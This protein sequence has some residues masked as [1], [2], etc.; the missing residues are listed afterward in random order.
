MALQAGTRL[1]PYEVLALIGAGG[2]GEVYRGRDTR[3]GREVAI[4]VLPA[5]RVADEDRRRRFVHEAQAASALNHPHIITIYEIESA[6]DSDFIVMEYVR[7]KS[8]DAFIPRQGM[9]LGDVLRIAIPVADALA[10]AHTRGIIHR[11]L[12]PANVMLGSDGA[13]KVLDFG[14]AKLTSREAEPEEQTI[15]HIGDTGLSVP[16]TIAGT[17]AYMSP[18]Q[19]TGGTVDARS[20]IF[21]FGAMLYEMVTG[22]RAFAGTST[23]DTLAAVL[24]AQPK[25]L[26]DVVADLPSDLHKIILRCLRKDPERRFQHMVDVKLALQEVKEDS[27]SGTAAVMVPSKRRSRLIGA[28]AASV[29]LVAGF[30]AWRFWPHPETEA[31][32][33]RVVPLTALAGNESQPTFSPDGDQV[34][35]SWDGGVYGTRDIYVKLVGSSEVRQLTMDPAR[36]VMPRWSPDGRR[37]AFVRFPPGA[38]DGRIH[39][40]SALGGPPSKLSDLSTIDQVAWSPDGRVVAAVR[41]ER[42]GD[43]ISSALYVIPTD[44]GDPRV[45]TRPKR[46]ATDWTPVFS[47]DGRGLAYASCTGEESTCDVY[48]LGLD[49]AYRPTGPPRQ[50]T[51]HPG[52]IRGLAWSRDG[53]SVIYGRNPHSGLG[54]LWRVAVAGDR[55]A[56]R[57]EVAG[58]GAMEPATVRSRD[59]LAFTRSFF[60]IDIYRLQPG[61]SPEPVVAGS[62]ADFQPQFSPDGR[63][64]VF[65]TAR[66]GEVSEIWVAAA[67]GS[68]A[69]QLTAGPGRFQG[70]PHWS[71][72]GRRIA[73]DSED[74]EGK[75]HI[76]TIDV[77]GGPPQQITK[78]PG[79]Q[80]VP[81]W[82]RDGRSI[83]FVAERGMGADLWRIPAGGGT[84]VRVTQDGSGLLGIESADGKSL[85][86]QP[87]DVESPLL[88]LSLTGGPTRQLVKCAKGTAFSVASQSLYY[89]ECGSDPN[90][91]VHVMDS[92]TGRDRLLGR[93]ERFSSSYYPM[94]LAVSPDGTTILYN[95]VV[96][97]GADLMLIE[98]FR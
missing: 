98:N 88:A 83:Y 57:L 27:E 71:P 68:G 95:K 61:R 93:L 55:P 58:L 1:G 49:A 11:D 86:Y 3:L 9:R 2:M 72:D 35:F 51:R 77:E 48:V 38:D 46:P 78:D 40:M 65:G 96:N 25:P 17:A 15:T 47:P 13:V 30:T 21:S 59:R 76:W 6:N 12:K 39:V 84:A 53:H 18:E 70:A 23:A 36:D 8:L 22:V 79:N 44:G 87:R 24:R 16:G 26:A 33:L 42:A 34:A 37:I 67:D 74:N 62:F 7:G 45:V 50:L 63:R 56:E 66:A 94:G 52:D 75:W 90:P 80:N 92:S 97:H 43:N 60:D 81:T 32:P 54:H 31:P 29:V 5:E 4:K 91:A 82:S 14:L 28:L 20:D 10:S 85:V 69:R 89:V 73:F 64:I 19:A 41:V